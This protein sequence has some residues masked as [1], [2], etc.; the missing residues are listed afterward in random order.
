MPARLLAPRGIDETRRDSD[1]PKYM[2]PGL[3]AR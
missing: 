1:R 2:D 3:A